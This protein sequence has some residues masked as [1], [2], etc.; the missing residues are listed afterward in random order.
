MAAVAQAVYEHM[1]TRKLFTTAYHPQTNGMVERFMQSLAQMLAMVVDG[2]HS[3]WNLWLNHVAFVYNRSE[4]ASTGVSPFLLA[5]GREP[6]I[7]LHQILGGLNSSV[8]GTVSANITELVDQLLTR[9]RVAQ[10][11]MD[12]RH[13]LKRQHVLKQ[14]QKLAEA[15]GLRHCFVV[16]ER[17]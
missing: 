12:K 4:H 7:A 8:S 16:W 10:S 9:Q 14:N 3:D 5:T 15:L 13:E 17:S 6:C 1:G 11:V 2:S